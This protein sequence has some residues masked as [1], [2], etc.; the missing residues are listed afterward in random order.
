[1]NFDIYV[2]NFTVLL[3][4]S[5]LGSVLLSYSSL[6]QSESPVLDLKVFILSLTFFWR[7]SLQDELPNMLS[8]SSLY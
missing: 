6:L 2:G 5:S 8:K 4:L 3:P 7:F 1:M